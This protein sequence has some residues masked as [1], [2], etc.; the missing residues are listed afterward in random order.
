MKKPTPRET[1]FF[2]RGAH[3]GQA[4][5]AGQPYWL[6][7]RAVADMVKEHGEDYEHVGLLHDVV[8]DTAVSPQDLVTMGYGPEIVTAVVLVSRDKDDGRTYM[9]WIQH[10][11]DSRNLLAIRVKLADNLH[12][13]Q[14][15]DQLDEETAQGLGHRYQRAREILL[16]ALDD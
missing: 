10:I 14:R 4:D 1:E 15:L 2:V 7:P 3:A 16:R 13:T 5:K 11:A 9:Q 12:N 8:E 6:H